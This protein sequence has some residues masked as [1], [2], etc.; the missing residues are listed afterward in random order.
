MFRLTLIRCVNLS[1][2]IYRVYGINNLLTT[3]DGGSGPM[4]TELG[5]ASILV[6]ISAV[7]LLRP[8][9]MEKLLRIPNLF[10]TEPHRQRKLLTYLD[11]KEIS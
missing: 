8:Y 5:I 10:E 6:K 1:L 11:E 7:L 3:I 4:N 2:H 9:M